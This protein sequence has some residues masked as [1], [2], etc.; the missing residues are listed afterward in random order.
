MYTLKPRKL[1]QL[2]CKE[3]LTT[4]LLPTAF[5]QTCWGVTK[6]NTLFWNNHNDLL[7]K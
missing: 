2:T 5:T 3:I 4:V 1:C 7:V 6:N